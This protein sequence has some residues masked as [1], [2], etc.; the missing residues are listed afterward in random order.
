MDLLSSSDPFNEH[1]RLEECKSNWMQRE[2]GFPLTLRFSPS[3]LPVWSKDERSDYTCALR[4]FHSLKNSRCDKH[5]MVN[6]DSWK[7]SLSSPQ[8]PL[9]VYP[10]LAVSRRSSSTPEFPG[11]SERPAKSPCHWSRF[12]LSQF[13]PPARK[14]TERGESFRQRRSTS[15]GQPF[16]SCKMNG[17]IPRGGGGEQGQAWEEVNSKSP[18]NNSLTESIQAATLRQEKRTR[19]FWR[20]N[21]L[22][23]IYRPSQ[24]RQF[25]SAHPPCQSPIKKTFLCVTAPISV[26][27]AVMKAGRDRCKLLYKSQREHM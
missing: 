6:S 8:S 15:R 1:D 10:R 9:T 16:K 4:L 11:G 3:A 22:T 23:N 17:E 26:Q 5:Q 25:N 12:L 18:E 19:R 27:L 2:A 7:I 24:Y 20:R 14:R 13:A 21:R